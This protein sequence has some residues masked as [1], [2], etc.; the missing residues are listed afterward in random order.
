MGAGGGLGASE[1][2][3]REGIGRRGWG[4]RQANRNAGGTKDG[5]HFSR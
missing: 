5:I 1:G 3:G 4:L 2:G